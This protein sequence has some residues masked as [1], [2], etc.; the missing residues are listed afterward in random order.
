MREIKLEETIREDIKTWESL[1]D[2]GFINYMSLIASKDVE[3]SDMYQLVLNG[4]EL[5]Y[6]SLQEINA[7]VKTMIYQLERDYEV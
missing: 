7:I 3:F 6:G 1:K 4:K 2:N 5:W